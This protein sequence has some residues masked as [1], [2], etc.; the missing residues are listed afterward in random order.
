MGI[1]INNEKQI[2]QRCLGDSAAIAFFSVILFQAD[3]N[4]KL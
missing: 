4:I 3:T 1:I 2:W